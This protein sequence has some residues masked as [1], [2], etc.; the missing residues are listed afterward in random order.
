MLL[1]LTA[2]ALAAAVHVPHCNIAI[3]P[4]SQQLVAQERSTCS[5]ANTA[6]LRNAGNARGRSKCMPLVALHM[7]ACIH[8]NC[9]LCCLL[10]LLLT[11]VQAGVNGVPDIT[12]LS[13]LH[14]AP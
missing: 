8:N 4:H 14:C 12:H 10:P 6:L 11:A 5:N 3:L 13:P 1:A 7:C 9:T 2:D